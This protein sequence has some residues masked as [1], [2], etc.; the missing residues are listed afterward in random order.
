[1][2]GKVLITGGAGFLGSSL[3]AS[4]CGGTPVVL[5][6]NMRRNSLAYS[7]L[8]DHPNVGLVVGD[9]CDPASLAMAIGGCRCVVHMASVAGVDAVCADPPGTLRT[10]VLGAENVLRACGMLDNI[11]RVVIV[12]SSEVY[13]PL[14]E[15]VTEDSELIQAGM[16]ASRWSYALGKLEAERLGLAYHAQHGLPVTIVRP[17]NVYGPGQT[18]QGAVRIFAS[19][20]LA[21]R[22][23]SLING[24]SQVRAWCYLDD[25]IDGMLRVMSQPAAVGQVFNLGNPEAAHTVRELA[26]KVSSIAGARQ[27]MRIVESRRPEVDIRIP[28]IS[29]ARRLLGFE[30]VVDIDSGLVRT[31]DWYRGHRVEIME[32]VGG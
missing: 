30:P 9:V 14:A 24:G 2:Y 28:D 8:L 3:A 23:L 20:A 17:F 10:S 13:G 5:L 21:G 1:M 18:G 22:P 16:S 32:A 19:R 7:A 11:E 27:P 4:L 31:L 29:K 15:N 26:E 25:F 6:D 12:S